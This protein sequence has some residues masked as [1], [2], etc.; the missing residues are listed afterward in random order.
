MTGCG[1][2]GMTWCRFPCGWIRHSRAGGNDGSVA[3]VTVRFRFSCYGYC[4]VSVMLEF[5]ET[6]ESSFPRRRES[7][8]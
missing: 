5:R 6:Y 2:V 7:R 8:P 1:F 3:T 4:Q